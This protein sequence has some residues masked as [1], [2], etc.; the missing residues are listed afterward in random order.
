M[1]LP[2]FLTGLASRYYAWGSVAPAPLTLREHAAT[3]SVVRG[4]TTPA[5]MELL[6]FAV[7]HLEP[8]ECYLETGTWH[9]ATLIG[10]IAANH[11]AHGYA[12]DD[13][14]MTGFDNDG[15]SPR[16]HWHA[17]VSAF[18]LANRATYIPGSVPEAYSALSIPPVGV[19]LF[20]G[21]KQT[22]EEAY[23]GIKGVLPLLAERAII[24][25]DDANTAQIRT[26]AWH[27]CREYPERCA[28]VLDIPTPAN[29]YPGFWNGIMALG[30][31]GG[32]L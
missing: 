26:A 17:N 25:L 14:S 19:F 24:I 11:E 30:W 22:G 29:A 2:A 12:I 9:G 20:D 27:L 1:D 15:D 18:G 10:A 21:G 31:I 5:A 3:L 4:M 16:A 7:A 23:Q 6:S 32:G 13:E 8:G 28:I